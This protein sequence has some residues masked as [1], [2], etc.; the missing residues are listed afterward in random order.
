MISVR[1]LSKQHGELKVLVDEMGKK[2]ELAK[3]RKT[4]LATRAKVFCSS[5]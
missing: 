2:I 3:F 1:K 5:A 4:E